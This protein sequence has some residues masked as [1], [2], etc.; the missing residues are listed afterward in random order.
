MSESP[1]QQSV[2]SAVEPARH[3][4]WRDVP[5]D[6]GPHDRD[7]AHSAALLILGAIA[8]LRPVWRRHE[9]GGWHRR[10]HRARSRPRPDCGDE[11]LLWK[12]LHVG[13]TRGVAR[14]ITGLACLMALATLG[15]IT[16]YMGIRAAEEVLAVGYGRQGLRRVSPASIS[17]S[18]S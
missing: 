17:T 5:R 4:P 14:L 15:V 9:E 6:L 8:L 18:G 2:R 16:Y 13:R 7:S 1:C 12:E 10:G 11:P 3:S